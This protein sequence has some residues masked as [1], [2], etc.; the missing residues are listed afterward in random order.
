[1]KGRRFPRAAIVA[2]LGCVLIATLGALAWR[3]FGP[4]AGADARTAVVRRGVLKAA[5]ETSGKLAAR[6]STAITSAAGGAVRI[7]AVKEGEAVRRGDVLIVLDDGPALADIARAERA[8]EAAETKVGVARQRAARDDNAL[9]EAAVAEQEAANARAALVAANDRLVATLIVAPF[10]GIVGA[11]RLGEG[12]T[13]APGGEAVAM[14]D[15]ADLIV[16]ADLDEVDRPLIDAGQEVAVTVTA[17]PGTP[18]TGRIAALSNSAQSRGGTTIYP[19]TVEFAR[20]A[21]LDL[22]VG[23]TAELRIVTTAREGV[24][25]VPSGV[26]RRAGEN[27]YAT[28]LRDGRQVDVPVRTGARSGDEV[29]IAA[30]LDE[31]D[32]VVLR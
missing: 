2:A 31:G 24:L 14:V 10:D 11:V 4:E 32:V 16:T 29:E 12:A 1:M 5:I 25:I 30:G 20:P 26:V 13:Y 21:G 9:G 7:V 6:R 17:F 8:V 22:K 27:Q 23:M 18:L 28:V 15:P 19:V 3:V